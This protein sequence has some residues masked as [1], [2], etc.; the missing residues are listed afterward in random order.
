V[1]FLSWRDVALVRVVR[2]EYRWTGGISPEAGES[3]TSKVLGTKYAWRD[4][5]YSC[6]GYR[7]GRLSRIAHAGTVTAAIGSREQTGLPRKLSTQAW[8]RWFDVG[9]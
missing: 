1:A 6:S 7:V 9:L 8:R 5:G 4:Q 2:T 3:R